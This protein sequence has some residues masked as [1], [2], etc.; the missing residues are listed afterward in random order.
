MKSR[1]VSTLEAIFRFLTNNVDL[2]THAIKV[3]E[4]CMGQKELEGFEIRQPVFRIE[5]QPKSLLNDKVVYG[6]DWVMGSEIRMMLPLG[7]IRK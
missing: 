6:F 4:K 7:V 5:V 2:T 1:K 3:S